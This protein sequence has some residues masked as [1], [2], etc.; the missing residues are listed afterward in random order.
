MTAFSANPEA[1]LRPS[2]LQVLLHLSS[3]PFASSPAMLAGTFYHL[4][5]LPSPP[6]PRRLEQ[7]T[8]CPQ[9]RPLFVQF[10]ANDP[11]YLI[12]AALMVQQHCDAVDINFGCPQRIAKRGYYGAFL[13]DNLPLVQQLVSGLVKVGSRQWRQ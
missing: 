8:T 10:C 5:P 3:P 1:S 9:D 2:L 4:S 7:F 12:K 6:P 11:D 13:M